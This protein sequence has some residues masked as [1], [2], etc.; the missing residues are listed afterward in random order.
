MEGR[1]AMT[2]VGMKI[3]HKVLGEGIVISQDGGRFT[4]QFSSG[5]KQF[6]Y[7]ILTFSKYLSMNDP[8]AQKAIVQELREKKIAND[9][10]Q[11]RRRGSL[12]DTS[13]FQTILDPQSDFSFMELIDFARKNNIC[14]KP[15]CTTCGCMPF[16]D[17]LK[18]TGE[19]NL[20]EKIINVSQA[21]VDSADPELWYEPFR[22]ILV[23]FP[24]LEMIKCP[25]VNRYEELKAQCLASIEAR[26]ERGRQRQRE[27]H[28]RALARKEEKAA[29]SQL[30]VERSIEKRAKYYENLRNQQLGKC[31]MFITARNL[32]TKTEDRFV[33]KLKHNFHKV[34]DYEL[35]DGQIRAWRNCYQVLTKTFSGLPEAYGNLWVV[36]EYV[37]PQHAPGTNRFVDEKHIRSDVILVSRDVAMVLEFKQ[38]AEAFDGYYRQANKYRRRLKRFHEESDGMAIEAVLVLTRAEDYTGALG[39]VKGCSPDRLFFELKKCFGES[40][41]L[42]PNITRWLNS[43]FSAQSEAN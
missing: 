12:T 4:V 10:S 13:R 14:M 2:L 11:K 38:S 8:D 36:F 33:H 18:K 35:S 28:L 23:E 31:A 43:D 24:E 34:T 25:L 19:V 40:P 7:H 37:L 17:M 27:E 15:G 42:H 5:T 41:E 6:L 30:H 21:C 1:A 9:R 16:R 20:R 3:N 29:R 22:I 39:D 32:L 26:R